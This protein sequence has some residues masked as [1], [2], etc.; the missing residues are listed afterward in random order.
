MGRLTVIGPG[1]FTT[2]Q[3]KGRFGYRAFGVPVSGSMDMESYRMA[4]ELVG[5]PANSPALEMTLSG[6]SYRF[7]SE[8]IIAV[9]GAS[10]PV[11]L[12]ETKVQMNT[13][14]RVNPGEVLSIG[15]VTRGARLYLAIRGDWELEKVM[16][17]YSTY[18]MGNFGGMNGRSLQ[19]GDILVWNDLQAT[20]RETEVDKS[21]IRYFSSKV[22]IK[23]M[24]GPEWDLL[25][26]ETQQQLLSS[27]FEVDSKSNRMGI[28]LKGERL[29]VSDLQMVSSPVLPGIIQLP[30]NGHPII[31]MNDGQ[32]IG[33]YPRIA[34]VL[35]EELWRLGQVKSGDVIRFRLK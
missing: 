31:L 28:R 2:I 5:N 12:A 26:S 16:S 35:D 9:T 19:N 22:S 14:I 15:A 3:D 8:A 25:S 18:T 1:L 34:K 13:T 11:V 6:G 21:R 29:R 30:P 20:F 10:A 33:G 32:T 27:K 24:K 17:S 4:N 7:D 23:I